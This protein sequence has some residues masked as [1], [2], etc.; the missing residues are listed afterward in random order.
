[1][2]TQDIIRAWKDPDFF[3]SLS[4]EQ[5][6]QLPVNPIGDELSQEDLLRSARPEFLIYSETNRC[7][8][9]ISVDCGGCA[10]DCP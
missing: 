9:F 5:R 4:A 7:G 2:S 6:A 10:P 3:A 1:M 8:S